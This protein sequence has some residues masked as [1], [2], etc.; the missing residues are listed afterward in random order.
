ME[1][2]VAAP[3]SN[4]QAWDDSPASLK[5]EVIPQR[6]NPLVIVGKRLRVARL[7]LLLRTR[8]LISEAGVQ[9]DVQ[10]MN[11]R[12]NLAS[13]CAGCGLTAGVLI[14]GLLAFKQVL[15]AVPG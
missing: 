15:A 7:P 6:R 11:R 2:S 1:R 5:N 14:V 3:P 9:S 12:K 13:C 8:W 4:L 10:A